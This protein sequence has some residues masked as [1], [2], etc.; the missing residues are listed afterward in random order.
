[1]PGE[2]R[3]EQQDGTEVLVGRDQDLGP[4]WKGTRGLLAST[5]L[6]PLAAGWRGSLAVPPEL[7]F[8]PWALG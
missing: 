7:V 3:Q 4:R 8:R 5:D 6:C 2:G 1:M